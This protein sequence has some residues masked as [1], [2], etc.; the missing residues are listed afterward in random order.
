MIVLHE[1]LNWRTIA[2]GA[3]IML[4]IGFIVTHRRKNE[5]SELVTTS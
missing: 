3:M 4:G 1:E 5:G 2:G